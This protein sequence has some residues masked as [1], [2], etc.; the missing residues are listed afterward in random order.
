MLVQAAHTSVS[1]DQ[2]PVLSIDE[3]APG[4]PEFSGED[5]KYTVRDIRLEGQIQMTTNALSTGHMFHMWALVVKMNIGLING[6]GGAKFGDLISGGGP[7]SPNSM[8]VVAHK[9]WAWDT[10]QDL[11]S[12]NANFGFQHA[13]D[14]TWDIRV[15][16]RLDAEDCIA[17]LWGMDEMPI[18]QSLPSATNFSA[19]WL[20]T[21]SVLYAESPRR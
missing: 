4:N 20:F 11:S 13:F 21:R 7:V 19:N 17:I 15:A 3:I 6:I 1:C 8:D 10:A 14:V 5:R 16:R 2:Q 18:T 9:R 12:S